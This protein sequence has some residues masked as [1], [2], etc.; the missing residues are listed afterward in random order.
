MSDETT[1]VVPLYDHSRGGNI[2]PELIGYWDRQKGQIYT[3]NGNHS[4]AA[5]ATSGGLNGKANTAHQRRLAEAQRQYK[6]LGMYNPN[7]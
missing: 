5:V 6:I 4:D 3:P 7:P 1:A 2:P